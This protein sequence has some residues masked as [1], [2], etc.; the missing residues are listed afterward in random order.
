MSEL[1]LELSALAGG[2]QIVETYYTGAA[3]QT[4]QVAVANPLRWAIVFSQ[5]GGPGAV[6]VSTRENAKAQQAMV[7]AVSSAPLIISYRQ[8]YGLCQQAWWAIPTPGIAV[9]IVA[10]E[11]LAIQ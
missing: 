10:I 6:Y 8:L 5:G 9:T 4:V 2:C 7:L 3:G 1:T 11:I